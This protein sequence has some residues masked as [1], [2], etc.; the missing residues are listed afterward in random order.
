M[1][2]KNLIILIAWATIISSIILQ[3]L[4]SRPTLTWLQYLALFI[5]SL[6][7]G[8]L[9]GD[10]KEIIIGYFIT[11]PLSF[12]IMTFCLTILPSITG[13]LSQTSSL[14]DLLFQSTIV[15]VVRSTFPSV[16][17]LCLISVILGSVISEFFKIT[18]AP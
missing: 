6:L 1:K 10:I 18:D 5:I 17:I 15:M 8:I 3:T 12:L 11:I 2:K 7:A 16:W 13:K 14:I 4:Y 9:I